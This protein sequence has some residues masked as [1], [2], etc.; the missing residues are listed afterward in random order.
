MQAHHRELEGLPRSTEQMNFVETDRRRKPWSVLLACLLFLGQNAKNKP[1]RELHVQMCVTAKFVH[2]FE[3]KLTKLSDVRSKSCVCCGG[4]RQL[5][6]R[7]RLLVKTRTPNLCLAFAKPGVCQWNVRTNADSSVYRWPLLG[8][9]SG[10]ICKFHYLSIQV[11]LY[12]KGLK[13]N[14]KFT[15][16]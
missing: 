2:H 16:K 7:T 4:K 6:S 1:S 14:Y 8:N 12:I 3:N 15:A 5:L 10:H 11:A 13:W 9:S